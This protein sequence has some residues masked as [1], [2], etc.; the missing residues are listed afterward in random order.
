MGR[1]ADDIA[2]TAR[3]FAEDLQEQAGAPLDYSVE[4][5]GA[6]DG[7][8]D[9]LGDYGLEENALRNISISAGCYVFET[10]RRN[11]GGEYPWLEKEG[12][13]VLVA[14][15]PEFSVGIKVWEKVRGRLENG[16]EDS[17]PFYIQGYR[18]HIA[19]GRTTPG[20]HV[21]IG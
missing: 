2:E 10:A 21:T 3:K 6:V 1:L 19:T 11:C 15:R 18:E 20:Y 17:I 5:L 13:P 9:D 8:L 12:Q 14:G 7:L 4:S 16:P